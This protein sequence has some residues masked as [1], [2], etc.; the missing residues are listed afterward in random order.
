MPQN[1]NVYGSA[2]TWE[3]TPL[4]LVK[5]LEIIRGPGSA[6]YGSS[7][8]NG[9]LAINTRTANSFE[10]AVEAQVRVGNGNTQIRSGASGM[11]D[12]AMVST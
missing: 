12:V 3:I 2:F 11:S 6:L 9:V 7:A 8:T 4:F 10:P 5:T 1:D